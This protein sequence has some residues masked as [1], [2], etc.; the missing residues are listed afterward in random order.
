[1]RS[2]LVLTPPGGPDRDH[3]STLVVQDGFS[4]LAFF[5]PWLW[6]FWNRLWI[7][8]I[9]A[10]LMQIGTGLLMDIPGF[11]P[12]GFLAGFAFS[13]LIGLEGRHYRS[14][15][16]IRSGWTLEMVIAAPDIQ[17]AEEIYFSGL[18]QPEE[19]QL[20]ASAEWA[21]QAK[22]PAAGWQ[23]PEF[24]LFDYQGGR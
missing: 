21:R 3:R 12:A 11:G 20:P 13:L 22:P 24:G 19:K 10:L 15:V 2:Y 16:L 14:E 23:G 8:G 9:A 7:T 17:L 6:L 4:W 5:F 18:P 1:M